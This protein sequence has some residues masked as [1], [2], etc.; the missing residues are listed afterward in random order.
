MLVTFA[1]VHFWKPRTKSHQRERFANGHWRAQDKLSTRIASDHGIGR[2]GIDD[3]LQV[4]LANVKDM[5]IVL[6]LSDGK[7]H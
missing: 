3:L 6:G 7:S 1:G 2:R 5:T 4:A